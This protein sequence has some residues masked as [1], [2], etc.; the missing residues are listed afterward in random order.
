MHFYN[1]C[2]RWD[3]ADAD[4]FEDI[5]KTCFELEPK[6]WTRNLAKPN[7]RAKG[8][9]QTKR[10]PKT[11]APELK[12]KQISK[13]RLLQQFQNIR[14]NTADAK[15]SRVLEPPSHHRPEHLNDWAKCQKQSKCSNKN[16]EKFLLAIGWVKH[17]VIYNFTCGR[18]L[19]GEASKWSIAT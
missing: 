10:L 17:L 13:P 19:F 4:A 16:H 7:K 18:R 2:N 3:A 14:R 5:W 12:I 8:P 6:F 15:S 11:K 9:S 1:F